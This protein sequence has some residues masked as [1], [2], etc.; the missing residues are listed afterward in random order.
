MND[1]GAWDYT[2]ALKG[3]H[4]SLNLALAIAKC[5]DSSKLVIDL[6]CGP[7]FYA[8]TLKR[9]GFKTIRAYDGTPDFKNLAL[10]DKIEVLDL[11][12]PFPEG[13]SGQVICLE[14]GEHIPKKYMA[15]FL[16]NVAKATA[17]DC[18][19]I[20]SWALPNQGGLG[21]VNELPNDDVIKEVEA[22][23]FSFQKEATKEFRRLNFDGCYWFNSTIMV[24]RK[25]Q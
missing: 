25:T 12:E 10:F 4:F 3:H 7:G 15:Q 6:G 13:V 24:F 1:K 2:D 11:T 16:D 8:Q 20:L 14:V 17:K 5:F 18:D 23:G 22:R 19:L 9:E 21:H